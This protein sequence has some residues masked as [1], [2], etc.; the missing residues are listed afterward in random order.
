MPFLGNAGQLTHIYVTTLGENSGNGDKNVSIDGAVQASDFQVQAGSIANI[1]PTL[2]AVMEQ[3]GSS[4]VT[5]Q[6]SNPTTSLICSGEII[7]SGVRG[8]GS[9]LTNIASSGIVGQFGSASIGAGAITEIKLGTNA[10]TTNKINSS[11]VTTD[12]IANGSV[13]ASKLSN[14]AVTADKINDSA[15]TTS[16]IAAGSVTADKIAAG[17]VGT[18][19][20]GDENVTTAKLANGSVTTAKLDNLAV[21][22][23]KLNIDAVTTDKIYNKAVTGAKIADYTISNVNIA[24]NT[25]TAAQIADNIITAAQIANNTI[26]NVEIANNTITGNQI[27]DASI[28]LTKLESTEFTLGLIQ[29]NEIAGAKLQRH[30]ITGGSSALT[31][32]SRSEIGLLTIHNDNIREST[33]NISKL[34]PSVTLAAVTNKGATTDDIISLTNLTDS[35]STTTG[36]LKV[37]GGVGVAGKVYAGSFHGGTFHGD[38]SAL[39]GISS[40]LQAITEGG[41]SSDRAITLTNDT[42]STSSSTGAL[43]VSGGVGITGN[44]YAT[45]QIHATSFHGDGSGLTGISSTLQAITE[46][47]ASSDRAITLTNDTSSTSTSTGALTVSGGVGITGNVYAGTFYGS[48]AGLTGISSTLQAI[49]EGGASSDRAITLTND[50]SST[51]TS[52]GALTVSGGV[53]ITGNVYAGTFY[54]SGAGLTGIATSLQAI[55]S[56]AGNSTSNKILITNGT[57]TTA[58]LTGALQ[59]TSGGL[60]VAKNIL[61]DQNLTVNGNLYVNGSTQTVNSTSLTVS[62]RIISIGEGNDSGSKDVGIIFGKPTANV[63]FFYDISDSKLKIGATQSSSL[64]DSITLDNTGVPVLVNGTMTATSFYGDGSNLTGISATLQAITETP[65]GGTTDQQIIVTN[66]TDTLGASSGAVQISGGLGVAKKIYAG[67]DITAFSDK[68]HKTNITRIENALDK[69][70]QLSGY[71]FDHD[72]ERKTG[73]IAQEIKAVLPEAVYGSEETTYSVA[74]GNLAGIIIEAIKEL[75]NEIQELKQSN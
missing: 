74:Y 8:D 28:P 36:A 22:A 41:A 30:T 15:V 57:N 11:A 16:K 68:R 52:T 44:V 23:A 70:C 45:E 6:L 12:K 7:A 13:T 39:T 48:G 2:Q 46:G 32:N 27:L 26:S 18:A 35:S 47:G 66:T 55:T 49:T 53:G 5:M 69:V 71:T 62:D 24:N 54:G 19:F 17:A 25:I 65:G 64:S 38:G 50:T 51:S 43:K 29:D 1:S 58:P 10:V 14:N 42:I 60:Y 61:T 67:G 20:I 33:I 72:G 3:D 63:A 37:S 59:V 56:G 73:V 34:D 75:R 9:G 40:T 4:T 21:T 31:G